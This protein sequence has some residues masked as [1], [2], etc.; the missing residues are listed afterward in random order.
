[1]IPFF[2]IIDTYSDW[3]VLFSIVFQMFGTRVIVEGSVNHNPLNE[4]SILWITDTRSP[5]GLVDEIFG[6]VKCPYYVVRYNSDKDV[7]PGISEGTAVSFVT[8]FAYKILNEKD[9][10]KK[11]YDASGENDEEVTDEVEFSDDE[12]EAQYKRSLSQEKRGIDDKRQGNR[13]NALRKKKTK[14]KGAEPR[15]GLRPFLPHGQAS[16]GADNFAYE[17][18]SCSLGAD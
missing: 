7:P 2:Y 13:Q 14:S 15:K 11:G 8:E 4:G 16:L 17:R 5:L 3:K 18:G 1:M 10:Y 12:K 6:P 9:L